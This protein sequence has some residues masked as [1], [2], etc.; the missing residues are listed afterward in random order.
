MVAVRREG[1]KRWMPSRSRIAGT[2]PYR[3]PLIF[4]STGNGGQPWFGG[5]GLR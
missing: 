2:D 3:L 1:A 4:A 5:D